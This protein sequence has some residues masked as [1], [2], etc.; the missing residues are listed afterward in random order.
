MGL[1]FEIF[2]LIELFFS[3]L[4]G[5]QARYFEMEQIPKMRHSRRGLLSMVN[6]GNGL[7]GSQF[8]ITLADEL[9]FLDGKHCIFGQISEGMD[10]VA[11]LNEELV[12]E[13][14]RPYRDVRLV[15]D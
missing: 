10:T 4:F 12:N 2:Q 8:Y 13:E 7:I 1:N 3:I 5:D 11:K 15:D 9:D 6:N 14:N